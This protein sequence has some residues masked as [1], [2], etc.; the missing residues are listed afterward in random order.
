MRNEV[1]NLFAGS[2]CLNFVNL[3]KRRLLQ[4]THPG[5]PHHTDNGQPIVI[6]AAWVETLQPFSYRVFARPLAAS[7]GFVNHCHGG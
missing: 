2:L 1:A 5:I 6:L 4:T 3:R 7:E